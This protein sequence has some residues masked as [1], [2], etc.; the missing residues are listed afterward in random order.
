MH[1]LG[2]CRKCELLCLPPWRFCLSGTCAGRVQG[3]RRAFVPSPPFR[4][5]W[6]RLV[7]ICSQTKTTPFHASLSATC[8]GPHAV[9]LGQVCDRSGP[10]AT[11]A[12][13]WMGQL[14]P[15]CHS[16]QRGGM[17]VRPD[18]CIQERTHLKRGAWGRR[19]VCESAPV[20]RRY[21]RWP[22]PW[23][24]F[25]DLMDSV[26][27]LPCCCRTSLMRRAWI[28]PFTC[29]SSALVGT[30][31]CRREL[32]CRQLQPGAGWSPASRLPVLLR[33]ESEG[34]LCCCADPNDHT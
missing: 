1:L 10:E 33:L 32:E 24:T 15:T 20:A 18:A 14:D 34:R 9:L 5:W 11:A 13:Q 26:W 12:S 6:N 17:W 4:A 25:R 21:T 22:F 19:G 23:R 2:R 16:L 27:A 3:S 8:H 29:A 31:S 30:I 28:A 7:C